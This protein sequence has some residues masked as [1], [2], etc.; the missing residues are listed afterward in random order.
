MKRLRPL[1]WGMLAVWASWI[2]AVQAV[3]VSKT[4]L[5]RWTPD[6][7]L[8][9]VVGCAARLHKRDVVF[10]ALVIAFARAA[11]S[12]DAPEALLAGYLASAALVRSVRRT[13][14]LEAPVFLIVLGLLLE[15]GLASWLVLVH[16]L[17]TGTDAG[18]ALGSAFPGM[19]AGALTTAGCALIAGG[20]VFLP[21][22]TPLRTRRW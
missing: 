6:L 11:Y 16:A 22:L 5:G 13:A 17:R 10:A 4:F 18:E 7:S 3:A 19:L 21:G 8:L 1:A 12:V 2:T 9:L 15:L 14:D 20:F